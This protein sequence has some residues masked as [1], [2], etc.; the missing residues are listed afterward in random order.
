[1][2]FRE[3]EAASFAP[4]RSRSFV[5]AALAVITLQWAGSVEA[6]AASFTGRRLATEPVRY[7]T[8][9]LLR[10]KHI[11]SKKVTVNLAS[12]ASQRA[13]TAAMLG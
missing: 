10:L 12:I 9:S 8:E 13:A 5:I 11:T 4:T 7:S 2:S 1:M 6:F 3:P